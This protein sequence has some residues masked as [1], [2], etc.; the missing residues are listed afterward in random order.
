MEDRPS[1]QLFFPL[2]YVFKIELIAVTDS[3]FP[4]GSIP[5]FANIGQFTSLA[6]WKNVARHYFP[7]LVVLVLEHLPEVRIQI[8]C[9]AIIIFRF[10][11]LQSDHTLVQIH[12]HGDVGHVIDLGWGLFLAALPSQ[13]VLQAVFPLICRLHVASGGY[14]PPFLVLTWCFHYIF[15]RYGNIGS[16]R[17]YL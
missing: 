11:N 10:A 12:E 15:G 8:Y 14:W 9:P 17:F 3:R 2:L 6:I 13:A 7:S 5:T 16:N 1:R 4:A